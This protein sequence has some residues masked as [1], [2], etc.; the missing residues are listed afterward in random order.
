MY[1]YE[2]EALRSSFTIG[3]LLSREVR[4]VGE[5]I[6]HEKEIWRVARR[7]YLNARDLFTRPRAHFSPLIYTAHAGPGSDALTLAS[8]NT[9][10]SGEESAWS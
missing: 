1:M 10:H 5:S 8:T 3:L 7:G 2:G 4:Y 6:R 9:D